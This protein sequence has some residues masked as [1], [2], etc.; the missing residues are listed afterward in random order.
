MKLIYIRF[1]VMH[2]LIFLILL[3][4]NFAFAEQDS[5]RNYFAAIKSSEVNVRIGPN[6]R[7]PIKWVF[8]KKNE[9]LEVIAKFENWY[10]IRDINGD[11][12]WIKSN[13]VSN[14]RFGIIIGAKIVT[15]Y[16]DDDLISK[17]IAKLEQGTRIEILECQKLMCYVKIKEIKGWLNRENIWGIYKDEVFD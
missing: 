3:L 6:V 16:K 14:K 10:K 15:L 2:L 12:G 5:F 17:V 11:E 8:V 13:M 4:T 9:P 7:Y 1:S